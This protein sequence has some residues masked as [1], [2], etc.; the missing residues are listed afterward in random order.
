MEYP[1]I[2]SLFKRRLDGDRSLIHGEHSLPEFALIKNWQCFE[3]I[4]GM[5]TRII[6]T[7]RPDNPVAPRGK[8]T[9][10]NFAGRSDN[11]QIPAS[12][13][14]Y[15]TRTFQKEKFDDIFPTA[16]KVVIFGEG[17][18]TKIQSGGNYRDD[19]SFICFDIWIEGAWLEHRNRTEICAQFGIDQVPY[20]GSFSEEGA[21]AFISTHPKSLIS[22][23]RDFM[24]EGIVARTE[25]ML[26]ARNGEPV[27]FKLRCEDVPLR[28]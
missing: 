7:S 23:K 10:L 17:Y 8:I 21:F 6:Y 13:I 2:H 25:P 9:E 24:M 27:K 12:L 19:V 3:K 15:L 5:N 22:K 4:D 14:N 16:N 26:I 1:K 28:G 11:A 18:G 20:L